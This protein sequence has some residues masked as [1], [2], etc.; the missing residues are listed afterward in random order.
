[1]W[2][3][4]YPRADRRPPLACCFWKKSQRTDVL[5]PKQSDLTPVER[6]KFR[7]AKGLGD[8]EY[9]SIYEPDVRGS[10]SLL[11]LNCPRPSLRELVG[12]VRVTRSWG[13]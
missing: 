7:L 13:G 9:G 3:E 4:H 5:W 8:R 1:M 6:C 11:R 12:P 10:I 2:R